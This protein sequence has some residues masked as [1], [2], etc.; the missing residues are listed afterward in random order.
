[1]AVRE[2]LAFEK[3][4]PSARTFSREFKQGP[5]MESFH[6]R[7]HHA[8]IAHLCFSMIAM[9][10]IRAAKFLFSANLS[11]DIGGKESMDPSLRSYES[12]HLQAE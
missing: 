8:V 10:F 2:K 4:H 9:L 11:F 5:E 12:N 3:A 7:N 6:N 1:M